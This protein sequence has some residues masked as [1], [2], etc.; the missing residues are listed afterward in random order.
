[1]QD[2]SLITFDG[3][4]RALIKERDLSAA[5]LARALDLSHV[6]VGNYLKGKATPNADQLL[7]MCDILD[8]LPHWLL[9]GSGPRDRAELSS[10]ILRTASDSAEASGLNGVEKQKKFERDEKVLRE[11]STAYMQGVDWRERAISAETKLSAVRETL[12]SLM[13]SIK[14][15]EKSTY[16]STILKHTEEKKS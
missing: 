14:P 7:K 13:D 6:A 3:R 11:Q 5:S 2:E 1:M 12:L 10:L 8:V 9:Y 16:R 4:L 15:A